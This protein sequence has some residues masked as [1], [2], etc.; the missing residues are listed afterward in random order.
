MSL[1]CSCG[2]CFSQRMTSEW[3]LLVEPSGEQLSSLSGPRHR[4]IWPKIPSWGGSPCSPSWR[5]E[6]LFLSLPPALPGG[7]DNFWAPSRLGMES[8]SG[9]NLQ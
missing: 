8:R 1:P 2:S 3:D 7:F 9:G 6:F 4:K 5:P